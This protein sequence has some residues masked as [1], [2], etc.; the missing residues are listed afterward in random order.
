MVVFPK[1][2]VFPRYAVSYLRA[3]PKQTEESKAGIKQ[4]KQ[5]WD[6]WLAAHPQYKPWTKSSKALVYLA[7]VIIDVKEN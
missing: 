2:K 7:E 4:Q 5:A 3:P 1:I 6:N